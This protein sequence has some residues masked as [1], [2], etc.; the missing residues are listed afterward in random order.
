MATTATVDDAKCD[1]ETNSD[2]IANGDED[3]DD[4]NALNPSEAISI[5]INRF[6]AMDDTMGREAFT[7]GEREQIEDRFP[8]ETNIEDIGLQW[9]K[10]NGSEL[11]TEYKQQNLGILERSEIVGNMSND[12]SEAIEGL[13][14]QINSFYF[15]EV[16]NQEG[17]H[18]PL[19]FN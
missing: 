4:D 12:T 2:E 10:L 1:T 16:S 11:D 15:Y 6:D 8:Q 17:S 13:E 7:S 3:D 5:S 19:Y 18:V 14:Q 9:L